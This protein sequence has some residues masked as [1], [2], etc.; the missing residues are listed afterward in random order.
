M[1]HCRFCSRWLDKVT[2]VSRAW[3]CKYCQRHDAKQCFKCDSPD[4]F[5]HATPLVS[6][7]QARLTVTA[8]A[9]EDMQDRSYVYCR[10]HFHNLYFVDG[11]EGQTLTCRLCG[12]SWDRS[13]PAVHL[14][15]VEVA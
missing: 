4:G 12:T 6:L 3:R 1:A 8:H 5:P 11:Y 9:P 14:E 2:D 10:V 7:E 13:G 15:A